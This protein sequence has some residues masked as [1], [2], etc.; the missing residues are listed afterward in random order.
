MVS[1]YENPNEIEKKIWQLLTDAVKDRSSEFRTP[2]FICGDEKDLDGRVVVLRKA[3]QQDNFIQYHSDIRSSKIKKIKKNPS[4]SILFYGKEEKIQLRV[5][6][7]CEINY[8]NDITKESWIK[9]GHISRKCYLVSNGP[10]TVSDKPTSGLDNKF[11]NF[12]FTKEESEAGYKNFC[13]IKCRIKSIE[14]LYL[15]AKGHRRL[16]INFEAEKKFN[17]LIP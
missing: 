12:D 10:G 1:Y 2:V 14:W 11:D 9:T 8:D 13:V 7:N 4:C 6:T 5:K 16:L 15:A 17:W 3:D